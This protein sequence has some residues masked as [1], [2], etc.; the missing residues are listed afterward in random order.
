MTPAPG[1]TPKR[2]MASE[3]AGFV[4]PRGRSERAEYQSGK[5][6]GDS[7]TYDPEF[8]MDPRERP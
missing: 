7:S 4:C 5:Q 8:R 2:H 1:K 6:K 3:M